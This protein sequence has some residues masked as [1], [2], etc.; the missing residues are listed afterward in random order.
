[1]KKENNLKSKRK[2]LIVFGLVVI[3]ALGVIFFQS[4]FSGNVIL[5][6]DADYYEGENLDGILKLSL[7]NGEFI[8]A[9]SIVVFENPEQRVEFPLRDIVSEEPVEGEYYIQTRN[10]SGEGLGF[11]VIGTKKIYPEVS[12]VF[13]VYSESEKILETEEPISNESITENDNISEEVVDSGEEIISEIVVANE[14]EVA[15]ENETIENE[16]ETIENE[17]IE[18]ETGPVEGGTEENNSELEEQPLEINLEAIEEGQT[19]VP[20]ETNPEVEEIIPEESSQVAEA[21]VEEP[22]VETIME[23]PAVEE[24]VEET[25]EEVPANEPETP[26]EE[27]VPE[28]EPSIIEKAASAIAM[29]FASLLRR[30]S[31]TGQVTL[32][33]ETNVSGVVS[34]GESFLYGLEDGQTAELLSGSVMYGDVVLDDDNVNFEI[35]DGVVVVSSNYFETEEGYG[36]DY[37]E[38]SFQVLE[39]NLSAIGLN[40]SKGEFDINFVYEEEEII[41]LSTVLQEGRVEETEEIVLEV[42][43]SSSGNLTEDEFFTLFK[44]FRNVSLETTQSEIIDGRLVR[45]YKIGDYELIS[46]YDYESGI[47]DSLRAQ[48]EKDK[49]NFL[50][51]L[52]KTLSEEVSS[53]EEVEEFLIS[54]SF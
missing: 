5:N 6:L 52:A 38:D 49:I 25:I 13:N 42:P 1:M 7:S 48:M 12:F 45:N 34:G 41:S 22:V 20:E 44:K 31:I 29:S 3:V 47:T 16:T 51:D 50:K 43:I 26:A 10:I 46:S 30:T 2:Y 36:S 19:N 39:I 54:S 18:N 35:K 28:E 17:T 4:N 21:I 24:T 23:E 27:S 53:S 11:G 8:P 15:N 40:F 33:F 14:T 37:L 9:S 32:D